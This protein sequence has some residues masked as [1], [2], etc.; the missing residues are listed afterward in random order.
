V[1]INRYRVIYRRTDG[2]NAEGTEVPYRFDSALTFTVP[3]DGVA[4]AGF[5]L[6]RNTAKWEAPLRA[7]AFDR[8]FIHT[9]AEVTFYGRDQ[10][11]NDVSV[12]ASIGIDFADFADPE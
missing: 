7:L 10:A 6:V 2:R 8:G 5:Q 1:T 3:S 11:G 4:T 12:S 9:I